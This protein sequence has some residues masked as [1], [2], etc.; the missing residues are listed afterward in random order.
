MTIIGWW[1]P[2]LARFHRRQSNVSE[3]LGRGRGGQVERGLV[4]IGILLT[5]GITVQLL[6]DLVES[7][8]AET[9]GGVSESSGGP[10]KDKSLGS[11]LSKGH[12]E[13]IAN[14]LV[15]LLVDLQPALDQVEGRDGSVGDAAGQSSAHRAQ[16]VVLGGPELAGVLI[17][18]SNKRPEASKSCMKGIFNHNK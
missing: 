10:A 13:A 4:E 12:F 15:L 6:E 14:R 8:L 3:E 1:L 7:K 9:L 2:Y 18:G 16:G 11:S 5:H 17:S